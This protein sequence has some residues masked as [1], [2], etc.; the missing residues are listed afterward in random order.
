MILR[1]ALIGAVVLGLGAVNY[2]W[3]PLP[4]LAQATLTLPNAT[5]CS[6]S[7]LASAQCI[8]A[9]PTRQRIEICNVGANAIT[10]WISPGTNAAVANG[11]TSYPLPG[12]ASSVASC[13][14]TPAGAASAGAAW[15]AISVTSAGVLTILE[16]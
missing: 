11:G 13:Y 8:T 2:F 12:L 1:S 5:S 3:N 6:V 14:R 15:N 4:A 7:A 9:N 10:I 16:Y